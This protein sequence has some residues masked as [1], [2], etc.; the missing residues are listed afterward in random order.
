MAKAFQTF[1]GSGDT[2]HELLIRSKTLAGKTAFITGASGG[3]GRAVAL[4]LAEAGASL[5]LHGNTSMRKV[6]ALA[7]EIHGAG[8]QAKYCQ[9]DLGLPEDVEQ[10]RATVSILAPGIDIFVHA[11]GIDLMA[12]PLRSLPFEQRLAAIW[13]VDVVAGM[14][15][16]RALGAQMSA[17]QGGS[18]LFFG[19]NETEQGIGGETAQLYAAAKGALLGFM[20]SLAVTLAPEVR[21]NAVSPGWILTRWAEEQASVAWRRAGQAASLSGRWGRPEEI[22]AVVRFLVSDEAAF[23]NKQNVIVDG[24]ACSAIQGCMK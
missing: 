15:L 21:V 18:I 10:L 9:A 3:I 13:Q 5:V 17:G 7:A 12:E 16:S 11:A 1:N 19:W 20:R 14:F 4:A 23:I 8:G 24:G 6:E 2:V 22:A